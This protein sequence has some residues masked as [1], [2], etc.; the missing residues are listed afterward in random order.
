M[1]RVDEG[2]QFV[3][4]THRSQ[5]ER[6]AAHREDAVPQ[7]DVSRPRFDTDAA[8]EAGQVAVATEEQGWFG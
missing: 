2:G 5:V 6:I 1:I 7:D 4:D 3:S 8:A